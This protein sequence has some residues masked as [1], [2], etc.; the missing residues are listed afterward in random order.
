MR[1][2]LFRTAAAAALSLAL[3]CGSAAAYRSE[4][5]PWAAPEVRAAWQLGLASGALF[6]DYDRPATRAEFCR[7]AC[8][9]LEAATG[10]SPDA[11]AA[12]LFP[13][14]YDKQPFPDT[15][16]PEAAFLAA[17]GVIGGRDDGAFDPEGGIT[18]EEAAKMLTLTAQLMAG[19]PAGAPQAAFADRAL[20]SGWALGY[21]DYVSFSGVMNGRED[22]SFDPRAGYTVQE[23]IL[24]FYRL[25]L[26]GV[27][28]VRPALKAQGYPYLNFACDAEELLSLASGGEQA[29]LAGAL[30][31][32]AAAAAE[33]E[34]RLS[35][36]TPADTAALSLVRRDDSG[37]VL[38]YPD[39]PDT[40]DI[41]RAAA[42]GAYAVADGGFSLLLVLPDGTADAFSL[43][44][45]GA[46]V[47]S[48]VCRRISVPIAE[49]ALARAGYSAGCALYRVDLAD[50]SSAGRID[51]AAPAVLTAGGAQFVFVPAEL[52]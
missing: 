42:A 38:P 20:I 26:A 50:D 2:T 28:P 32:G 15:S 29:V 43:T 12:A 51:F 21:V 16:L 3:L 9:F 35:V 14:G 52:A 24:T 48:G 49:A 34:A 27:S 33:G 17:A 19:A 11:L 41:R 31:R 25:W 18:R 45:G 13:S 6:G 1:H 47:A 40:D 44:Q 5:V 8:G 46:A 39:A 23:S 7:F 36:L 30:A 4:P 22:G 37:N 10:E